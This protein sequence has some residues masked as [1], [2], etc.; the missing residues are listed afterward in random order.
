MSPLRLALA[1]ALLPLAAGA[2]GPPTGE[3]SGYRPLSP[4]SACIDPSQVRSWND[5]DSTTLLIDAGRRKF[6]VELSTACPD[7]G[8]GYAIHLAGDPIHGRICGNIGERVIV[9]GRS[10]GIARAIPIDAETYRQMSSG[11]HRRE[12]R[13]RGTR[14][15]R[16]PAQTDS[17]DT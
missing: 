6:R 14:P 9:R 3:S 12:Q 5:V 10:C 4:L 1:L 11:E 17:P 8:F 7:L 15:A 2:A 13:A 16:K